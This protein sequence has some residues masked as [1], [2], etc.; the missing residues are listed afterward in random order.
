MAYGQYFCYTIPEYKEY[1]EV[2][3]ALSHD[4]CPASSVHKWLIQTLSSLRRSHLETTD[5]NLSD[6]KALPETTGAALDRAA[7]WSRVS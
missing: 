5:P 7:G 4:A 1:S 3:S 2:V 6:T